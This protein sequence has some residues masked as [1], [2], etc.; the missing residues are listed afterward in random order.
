[1]RI[2]KQR[3]RINAF[4]TEVEQEL[5]VQLEDASV[6][7]IKATKVWT[8]KENYGLHRRVVEYNS[9]ESVREEFMSAII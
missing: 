2:K 9:S 6:R 4:Q 5:A 7:E 1:M 8:Q 3:W